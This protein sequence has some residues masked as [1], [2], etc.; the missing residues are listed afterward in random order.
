MLSLKC[1]QAIKLGIP[2]DTRNRNLEFKEEV[3]TRD[4]NLRSAH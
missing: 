3:M 4:L 2:A 1:Y